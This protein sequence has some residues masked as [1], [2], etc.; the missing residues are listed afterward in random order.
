MTTNERALSA[1]MSA[2]L[3]RALARRSVLPFLLSGVVVLA[4]KRGW[5][6]GVP[7]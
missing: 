5:L 4:V 2:R 6:T 7:W 1:S 3:C